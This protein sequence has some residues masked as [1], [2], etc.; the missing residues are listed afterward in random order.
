[1]FI[2]IYIPLCNIFKINVCL[3]VVTLQHKSS[4]TV[5]CSGT[6]LEPDFLAYSFFSLRP[7]RNKP[8][9]LMSRLWGSQDMPTIMMIGISV[10]NHLRDNIFI[11]EIQDHISYMWLITVIFVYNC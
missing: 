9:E 10:K 1:M 3:C 7:Q 11:Q 4:E 5:G 2:I 6:I 8:C